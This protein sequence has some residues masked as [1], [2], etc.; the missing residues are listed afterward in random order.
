MG[1]STAVMKRIAV[2]KRL[3]TANKAKKRFENAKKLFGA[4]SSKKCFKAKTSM[5]RSEYLSK[6]RFEAKSFVEV[7]SEMSSES[8]PVHVMPLSIRTE[9]TV[10]EKPCCPN[11]SRET[12]VSAVKRIIVLE[13]SGKQFMEEIRLSSKNWARVLTTLRLENPALAKRIDRMI[14]MDLHPMHPP[15]SL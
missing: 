3:L 8:I 1:K 14:R 7:I 15:V 10:C 12:T 9:A 4:K 5:K 6:K 13:T 2:M 11:G